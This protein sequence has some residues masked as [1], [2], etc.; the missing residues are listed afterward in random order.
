MSHDDSQQIV[1]GET[2]TA[3]HNATPSLDVDREQVHVG[4]ARRVLIVIVAIYC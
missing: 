2:G 3:E 4:T 1:F